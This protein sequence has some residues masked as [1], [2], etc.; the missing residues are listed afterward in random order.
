MGRD[1]TANQRRTP[2][3]LLL[4]LLPL[5]ILAAGMVGCLAVGQDATPSG[6][7]TARPFCHRGVRVELY[8]GRTVSRNATNGL[9]AEAS[10]GAFEAFVKRR[11]VPHFSDGLALL[12]VPLMQRQ[13]TAAD[14]AAAHER[15]KMLVLFMART[16]TN[17]MRVYEIINAFSHEFASDSVM[18][19][20]VPD[21]VYCIWRA[22]AAKCGSW[23]LRPQ[24]GFT[25]TDDP[26]WTT[27]LFTY[28]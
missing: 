3:P 10:D 20:F 23:H 21:S 22:D 15:G 18:A 1:G 13:P 14:G 25:V 5:A 27:L 12:D 11:V 19:A 28:L 7:T 24:H 17:L 9:S 2:P 8:F 4:P 6:T 16:A 26:F